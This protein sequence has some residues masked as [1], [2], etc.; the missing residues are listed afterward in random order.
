MDLKEIGK[1]LKDQSL[2][3]LK[4]HVHHVSGLYQDGKQ[5]VVKTW[6]S[7]KPGTGKVLC[8]NKL[9]KSALEIN[10]MERGLLHFDTDYT[11]DLWPVQKPVS[12]NRNRNRVASLL[13]MMPAGREFT[14]LVGGAP[15]YPADMTQE[16]CDGIVINF[17]KDKL[18]TAIMYS[19][20]VVK[21]LQSCAAFGIFKKPEDGQLERAASYVDS[22]SPFPGKGM[23]ILR[24]QPQIITEVC[25]AGVIKPS[26]EQ[27]RIGLE[28]QFMA[29][30]GD[31]FEQ[32]IRAAGLRV[33]K[34]AWDDGSFE[35]PIMLD[36]LH[37]HAFAHN[38]I[39]KEEE[40][41]ELMGVLG[42]A[43]VVTA[44]VIH[45]L[46]HVY[47]AMHVTDKSKDIWS[48]YLDHLTIRIGE[49]IKDEKERQCFFR[50]LNMRS[51]EFLKRDAA[52]KGKYIQP[53]TITDNAM[54]DKSRQ[55][56]P[57]ELLVDFRYQIMTGKAPAQTGTTD[58]LPNT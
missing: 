14:V 40:I 42:G 54:D 15:Q 5:Y 48:I 2:H 36:H 3:D 21:A 46:L 23:M 26:F 19:E 53:Y 25:S 31:S 37:N 41:A 47:D 9:L 17:D 32:K 49:L 50:L 45:S 12:K 27:F 10:L 38:G 22:M 13:P 43:S 7:P 30:S 55:Y 1:K 57:D 35:I 4:H 18:E 52:D 8:K 39:E 34:E 24:M 11:V 56:D 6:M 28:T 51:D 20:P 44:H 58:K 33:K 29:G 16:G